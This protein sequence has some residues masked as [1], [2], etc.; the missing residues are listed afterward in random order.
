MIFIDPEG[1][2]QAIGI[3]LAYGAALYTLI[4]VADR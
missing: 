4:E 1:L 3:W 2:M